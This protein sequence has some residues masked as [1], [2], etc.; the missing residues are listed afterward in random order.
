M[1]RPKQILKNLVSLFIGEAVSSFLAFLITIFLARKLQDAGFGMLAFIQSIMVYLLLVVDSGLSIFG[2]RELAR[3]HERANEI[4]E[5][6][7]TLRLVL[8]ITVSVPSLI[9]IFCWTLPIEIRWLCFGSILGLFTQALNP[10]FIFQGRERMFGVSA[11]R[12]L[13][14]FIYL[15]LLL[16]VVHGRQQL[17]A[18]TLLRSGA[19]IA[20]IIIF[21]TI[22]FRN[23]SRHF[24]FR[25]RTDLWK[26]YLKESLV[27][28]ASVVV[29]KL[30]Y[31]FD[32]FM[33]G[34]MDKPEAVGWYQASYK[35]ILLFIGLAGLVQ[36]A[37]GPV[38][39]R[40]SKQPKMLEETVKIFATILLLLGI[41]ANCILVSLNKQITISLFGNGYLQSAQSLILLSFSMFFVFM[42]TIFMAPLLFSG[43]QKSYLFLVSQG[44]LLNIVL[45]LIFIPI[46][47]F[48]GAAFA[49]IASNFLIMILAMRSYHRLTASKDTIAFVGIWIILF[50][51]IQLL[52]MVIFNSEIVTLLVSMAVNMGLFIGLNYTYVRRL[53]TRVLDLVDIPRI[54]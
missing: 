52:A 32:T 11:W 33:L 25:W 7:L 39:A 6:V 20:V 19:E 10:E 1:I 44:A 30:Y 3:E 28:A 38:F 8:A 21:A 40:V 16:A 49:T 42:D 37:F 22:I 13:V 54:V 26:E 24:R 48:K 2:A 53:T 4:I 9:V 36:M 17:W 23:Y 31:S 27:M 46:Y 51:V 50:I 18:T 41:A 12:V 14:H 43:R 34:I 15:I 35:V 29:I 5:N 45:N 47:S